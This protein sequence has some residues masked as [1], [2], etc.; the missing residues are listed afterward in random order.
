[1]R[2]GAF[3]LLE[4]PGV[5]F[6]HQRGDDQIGLVQVE[7]GPVPQGSQHPAFD[8]EHVVFHERFVP[9]LG[10][11]RR[12]DRHAVV[13]GHLLVTGVDFRFVE[14]GRGHAGLQVV[15]NQDRG[16]TAQEEE[17]PDVGAD[18]VLQA[19][20]PRRL[21]KAVIAGPQ[22]GDED[23]GLADRAR[24]RVHHAQGVPGVVH[25]QLLARPVDLAHAWVQ[26]ADMRVI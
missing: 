23:L 8:V 1:M 7:E 18:P 26:L 5:E 10:R 25:E 24:G 6:L 12:N 19:L 20:R 21:G 16:D 3:E 15:R 2:A 4:G 22:R 11:A 17:G 13:L 14:A 9:G